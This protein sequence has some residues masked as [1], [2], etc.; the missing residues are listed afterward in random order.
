MAVVKGLGKSA[1]NSTEAKEIL[2]DKGI[3]TQQLQIY[4]AD[5]TK[6]PQAEK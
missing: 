6:Q 5:D 1:S 2:I 4:F 3:L